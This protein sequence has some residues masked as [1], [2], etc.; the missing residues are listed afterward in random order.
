MTSNE[1]RSSF[2]KYFEQN[3]H[4]VVPS[5]PLVPADDPTL[6]FTNAGM[7]Q[8]VPIFL[9]ER[10][11]DLARSLQLDLEHHGPLSGGTLVELGAKRAIAP[12]GVAR[13][14]DEL[15]GSDAPLELLV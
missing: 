5:S 1:I 6:L 9:G 7:N 8:F 2:L 13:V 11:P 10:A 15:A 3:G 4:R 12:A 14:L